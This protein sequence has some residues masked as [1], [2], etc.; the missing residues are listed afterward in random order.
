[1]DKR[2]EGYF[3]KQLSETEKEQFE[4]DLKSN[5]ALANELAAYL[6][7]KSAGTMD[8][9]A[10]NR[11]YHH[12][13]LQPVRPAKN[14]VKSPRQTLYIVSAAA[15]FLVGGI[16]WFL[17][18]PPKQDLQLLANGYAMENFTTLD[19]EM[20]GGA[21]SVQLAIQYY[22]KGQYATANKVCEQILA[23]DPEN[24]GAKKI[25][26]IVSLRLLDY[27]RAIA[28]FHQLGALKNLYPNPGKFYEAI[29][30]IQS[31]IPSNI[32]HAKTLLQE[33]IVEQLEGRD[34]ALKWM[35]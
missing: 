28:Y 20:G 14:K 32:P 33:V 4:A 7:S 22:N 3:N 21:D 12:S 2:I 9:E 8:G 27:D 34:E 30:L 5:V 17:L 35:D 1:M 10:K 16:A 26:G 13:G 29:A 6:A 25:A 11:A 23:N 24:A 31:G 19:V 18:A 15:A